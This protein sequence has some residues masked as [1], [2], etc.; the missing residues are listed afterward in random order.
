MN[1]LRASITFPKKTYEIRLRK[2]DTLDMIGSELIVA[3]I[4]A[5][6]RIEFTSFLQ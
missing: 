2:T 5:I 6:E 1:T 4:Y 3:R